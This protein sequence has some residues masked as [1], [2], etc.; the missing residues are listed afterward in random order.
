MR[1]Y[2]IFLAIAACSGLSNQAACARFRLDDIGL[3]RASSRFWDGRPRLAGPPL[4]SRD[5]PDQL[6][7][8]DRD[9]AAQVR[10]H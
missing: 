2:L 9:L 7:D 1:R 6:G 8:P 5:Q 3:T 4:V 10:L